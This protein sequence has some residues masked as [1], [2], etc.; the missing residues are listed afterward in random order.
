MLVVSKYLKRGHTMPSLPVIWQLL[1]KVEPTLSGLQKAADVGTSDFSRQWSWDHFSCPEFCVSEVRNSPCIHTWFWVRLHW[2]SI[3]GPPGPIFPD[4][5]SS[6]GPNLDP[7][8]DFSTER[9]ARLC[10]FTIYSLGKAFLKSEGSLFALAKSKL[11]EIFTFLCVEI[12]D[13]PS[14]P[15]C[16]KF[17]MPLRHGRLRNMC[18]V[19]DIAVS[20]VIVINCQESVSIELIFC[21]LLPKGR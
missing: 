3:P 8:I 18:Q 19:S 2:A 10:H 21:L 4:S 17:T 6:L 14:E 15:A 13:D 20:P 7:S 5:K 11:E 16:N 9:I 1:C 12:R